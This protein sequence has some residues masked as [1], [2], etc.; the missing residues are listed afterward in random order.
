M[1]KQEN[2]PIG[3]LSKQ[4]LILIIEELIKQVEQLSKELEKY[5]HPKNSSNTK[6][7]TKLPQNSSSFYVLPP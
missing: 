3:E 5:K 4:Q 7:K 6:L 2:I 1:N